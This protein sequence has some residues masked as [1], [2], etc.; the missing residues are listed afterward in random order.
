[1]KGV[2]MH[3]L[4]HVAPLLIGSIDAPFTY[5]M[6]PVPLS[7]AAPACEG[8][9]KSGGRSLILHEDDV[10]RVGKYLARHHTQAL[11][12][13]GKVAFT[14][15]GNSLREC[16]VTRSLQPGQR[17]FVQFYPQDWAGGSAVPAGAAEAVDVT[18][19]VLAMAPEAIAELR[20]AQPSA[21]VL[22]DPEARGHYGPFWVACEDALCAFFGVAHVSAITADI[23]QAR[24]SGSPAAAAAAPMPLK[25]DGSVWMMT[26]VGNERVTYAC[27]ADD[28]DHAISQCREAFPHHRLAAAC[29]VA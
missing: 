8:F 19:Q 15:V 14:L 3:F 16:N 12:S 26:V 21:E 29:C 17:L 2:Q 20:D 24:Q 9:I 27:G 23:L 11:T 7:A 10:L 13:D 28:I 1:M 18:D 25:H 5:G 22:V 6:L 4:R